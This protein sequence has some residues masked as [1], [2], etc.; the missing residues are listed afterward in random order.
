MM[1][2]TEL[3]WLNS[4]Y[5]N[6]DSAYLLFIIQHLIYL[7]SKL[8]R[9]KIVHQNVTFSS[10]A[11]ISEHIKQ[12]EDGS[13]YL[14]IYP[15]LSTLREIYSSCIKSEIECSNN[16]VLILSYYESP[17]KLRKILS[18]GFDSK[19]TDKDDTIDVRKYEKEGSLVIMDSLKGYFGSDHDY[20]V[21][22]SSNGLMTFIRQLLKSAEHLGK[23]GISVFADLGS[24]YHYNE[25]DDYGK[26]SDRLV[27]YELSL[28]SKYDGVKLKGFCIYHKADFDRRF[29][30]EQKQKLLNHHGK[31]LL[32]DPTHIVQ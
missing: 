23:N 7:F 26:T 5:K 25:Q 14:L 10:K 31:G 18:D 13:H 9:Y 21:D 8:W 30:E 11:E 28:P 32:I 16:I 22:S 1:T 2:L 3:H 27:D 19:N 17:D 6:M 4:P 24:F 29:T 12:A 15:G 20:G